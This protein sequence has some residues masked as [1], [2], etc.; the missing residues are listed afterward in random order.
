MEPV[1]LFGKTP[2]TDELLKTKFIATVENKG[3]LP[4]YKLNIKTHTNRTLTIAK[5][6]TPKGQ[7]QL[8]QIWIDSFDLCRIQYIEQLM[9]LTIGMNCKIV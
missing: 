3:N 8:W 4:C 6:N 2:I 7:L 1:N 5:W 9:M